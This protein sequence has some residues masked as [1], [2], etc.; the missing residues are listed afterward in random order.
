[1]SGVLTGDIWTGGC[2]CG[3]IRYCVDGQ[4]S[5][6]SICHCRMCQKASGNLFGA[7]AATPLEAFRWTRGAPAMFKTSEAAERGFCAACGTNLYFKYTD[8]PRISVAIGSLDTPRAL[9]ITRQYGIEGR[10]AALDV[11]HAL[12][13]TETEDDIPAAD[14]PRYASRQHPDHDTSSWP[15]KTK[16]P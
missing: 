13:A 3:A 11:L 16:T 6:A 15:P 9:T 8:K 5:N 4:L 7:F 14:R 10:I 1:M 2:Q 12:D